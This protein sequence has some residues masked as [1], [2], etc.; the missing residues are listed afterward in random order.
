MIVMDLLLLSKFEIF[1]FKVNRLV[2]N[3]T[4]WRKNS[5]SCTNC[6]KTVHSPKRQN[7]KLPKN[8]QTFEYF[9][10]LEKIKQKRILC[11]PSL[12][13]KLLLNKNFSVE[14]Q[15]EGANDKVELKAV[16]K[17]TSSDELGAKPAESELRVT[18]QREKREVKK[19]QAHT[20][21]AKNRANAPVIQN[22]KI[23][24]ASKNKGKREGLANNLNSPKKEIKAKQVLAKKRNIEEEEAIVSADED[25][26]TTK[27]SRR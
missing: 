15:N 20:R 6:Q 14:V 23:K 17:E 8:N 12:E 5:Y 2:F 7:L 1:Y 9:H 22:S 25:K 27:R 13:K 10:S 11:F 16:E 4:F 24:D 3:F 21:K 26:T 19:I 18:E